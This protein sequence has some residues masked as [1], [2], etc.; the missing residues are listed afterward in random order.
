MARIE[1]EGK[2]LMAA[3]LRHHTSKNGFEILLSAKIGRTDRHE[4]DFAL[5]MVVL[6]LRGVVSPGLRALSGKYR[7]NTLDIQP[8]P[9]VKG[10]SK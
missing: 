3:L 7:I 4:V 6:K 1:N 9:Q 8:A 2:S 10:N 5:K